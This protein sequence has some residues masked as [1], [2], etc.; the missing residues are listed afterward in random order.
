MNYVV[1]IESHST[2]DSSGWSDFVTIERGGKLLFSGIGS[3]CPNPIQYSTR[4]N[5][6]DA[7]GWISA[8]VYE[9]STI[10]HYKYGRC[11]LVN[12]GGK[13]DARYPNVNHGGERILT[14]VLIHAGNRNSKNKEWRGS[15]GCPT[16]HPLYWDKF[17]DALPIGKGILVIRDGV[18]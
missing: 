12:N 8:G 4:F 16:I 15:A 7:Y 11:C 14:E 5:W 1:T 2:P 18:K 10:D 17:S 3:T 13:V 9:I 6:R